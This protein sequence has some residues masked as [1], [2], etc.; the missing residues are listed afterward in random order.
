MSHDPNAWQCTKCG[1]VWA[2]G[3]KSCTCSVRDYPD[4]P[5]Q[6]LKFD[7]EGVLNAKTETVTW[8]KEDGR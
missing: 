8:T 4:Y 1:T 6:F 7:V 5:V 2:P 3:V